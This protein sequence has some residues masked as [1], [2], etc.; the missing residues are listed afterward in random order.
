MED[1]DKSVEA[2]LERYEKAN[3]T[4][5]ID[6]NAIMFDSIRDVPHLLRLLKMSQMDLDR[7][8]QEKD[9]ILEA[10]YRASLS[11]GYRAKEAAEAYDK[12]MGSKK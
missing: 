10:L 6:H 7:M 3:L 9:Q 8:Q 11:E 12:F 2:I 4:A 5:I 1:R